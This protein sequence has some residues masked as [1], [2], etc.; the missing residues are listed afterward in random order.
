MA[1][2][3]GTPAPGPLGM[4]I[5]ERGKVVEVSEVNASGQAREQGVLQGSVVL[6][7]SGQSVVGLEYAGV[8]ELLTNSERPVKVVLQ[9]G[10]SRAFDHMIDSGRV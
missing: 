6:E 7:V 5:K 2:P 1:T 10:A 4:T 9:V 3:G 8:R